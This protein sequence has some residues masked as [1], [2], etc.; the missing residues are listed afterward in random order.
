MSPGSQSRVGS[1]VHCF[2]VGFRSPYSVG[3]F[4]NGTPRDD[5]QN[6]SLLLGDRGKNLLRF[7]V[8]GCLR[9]DQAEAGEREVVAVGNDSFGGHKPCH[10]VAG[11]TRGPFF[12]QVGKVVVVLL[13]ELARLLQRRAVALHAVEPGFLG[14]LAG[15]LENGNRS[16]WA[17]KAR[18][19]PS[20]A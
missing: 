18:T 20:A 7:G 1:V 19:F 14:G 2:A 5:F 15:L 11:L 3:P 9:L 16:G 8:V 6:P 13:A 10:A 12:Q 4:N 17:C